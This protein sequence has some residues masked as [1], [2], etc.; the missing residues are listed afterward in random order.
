[1]IS[2]DLNYIRREEAVRKGG[3]DYTL[4]NDWQVSC[5]TFATFGV[6]SIFPLLVNT[7]LTMKRFVTY[8][9]TALDFSST[10]NY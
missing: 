9:D 10:K 6:P 4:F 8:Y 2:Y 1:M 5:C 3:T 7:R